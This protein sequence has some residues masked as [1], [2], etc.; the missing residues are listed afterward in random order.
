MSTTTPSFALVKHAGSDDVV[1]ALTT[2]QNANMDAIEDLLGGTTNDA[3]LKPIL[4]SGTEFADTSRDHGYILAV[5]ELSANRT[6]TLPLLT[7]N[8][9]FAFITFAQT[10]S[11]KTLDPATTTIAG[12]S[13]GDIVQGD[14]LTGSGADAL[15]RLAKGAANTFLSSDGTD[16]AYKKTVQIA[17]AVGTTSGPTTT[18]DS[19]ADLAEMSATLTTTG[20]DLLVWFVSSMHNASSAGQSAEICF[21]LDS[22]SVVGT[23][24]VHLSK[25]T[26]SEDD[27]VSNFYRFAA[28][29]AASHTVDV[30]WRRVGGAGTQTAR[31]TQRHILMMEVFP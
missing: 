27:V 3:D 13:T 10:L 19:F 1:V 14:I 6:V 21:Q 11:N 16:P 12:F 20:G 29:S 25:A 4:Q 2:N 8:D 17:F 31:T 28:P 7:A 23:L 24:G 26:G 5:S 9:T 18:S 22:E 30:Q 15:Q